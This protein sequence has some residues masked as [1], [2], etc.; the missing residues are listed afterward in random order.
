MFLSGLFLWC[1]LDK[2]LRGG[3]KDKQ[4][5]KNL[6]GTQEDKKM[7]VYF[8]WADTWATHLKEKLTSPSKHPLPH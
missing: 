8:S 4:K 6:I 3:K 2:N 5:T 7:V 1:L